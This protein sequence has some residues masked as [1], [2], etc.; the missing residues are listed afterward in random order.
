MDSSVDYIVETDSMK[1][2]PPGGT[3]PMTSYP[4]ESFLLDEDE[5]LSE[6]G[7]GDG[8]K[9]GRDS[10]G[11]RSFFDDEPTT[12]EADP[13]NLPTHP[14]RHPP[15]PPLTANRL[16]DAVPSSTIFD[17]GLPTPGLTPTVSR[18]NPQSA[19]QP[20][21]LA[22]SPADLEGPQQDAFPTQTAHLPFVLAY[23]SE[24]LAQQLTIVEKD[25]LDEIDWKELI[26]LRWKQ[27]S[28]QIRDW[29]QYLRTEEAR[30]VDVVIAR[31]NLVV[32]W[33]VSE[34]LLTEDIHE[35]ARCITKFIH[36]ATHARRYRNYAT[37]YQIAIALISNDV[38]SLKK[39]WALVPAA[40]MLV[41]TELEA[42]V[43]PLKN[44]HNLRLEMETATVD[45]GCIPFIGE[46]YYDIYPYRS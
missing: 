36:I 21:P 15:T 6:M 14:M 4:R 31:F 20:G 38:S 43:Q 23:D 22:D 46:C 24:I 3:L 41:M 40:E 44:F 17:R 42:L 2:I 45:D 27:S 10:H 25:A 8:A 12:P 30:G 7:S 35:R 29:V 26:E 32:K 37:M 11:V 34:V 19:P 33:V 28:P 39:T 1:R 16:N 9:S 13:D 5:D 18:A